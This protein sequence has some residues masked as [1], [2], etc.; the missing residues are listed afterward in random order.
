MEM[1]TLQGDICSDAQQ[2]KSHIIQQHNQ[3]Q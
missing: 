1:P 2:Y 3:L